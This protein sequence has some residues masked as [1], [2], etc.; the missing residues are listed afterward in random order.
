MP[1]PVW[2]IQ[3]ELEYAQARQA[4][5]ANTNR[6][7]KP[8]RDAQPREPVVY[9]PLLYKVGSTYPTLVLNASKA[10]VTWFGGVTAL[11]LINTPVALAEAGRPPR[12]FKPSMIS[13]MVGDAT[14]TV[15]RA[16]GGTGRRYIDYSGNTTGEAQAHYN[17][18]VSV[19]NQTP[20]IDELETRVAAIK[21]AKGAQLGDYGRLYLNL[22]EYTKSLV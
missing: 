13:A 18:P 16:Y 6:P 21:N 19:G 11:G 22:E 2:Q 8:T 17:A 12:N 1:K 4:Y 10:S 9:S 5:Y 14:P 15:K 7:I 3:R 20:T